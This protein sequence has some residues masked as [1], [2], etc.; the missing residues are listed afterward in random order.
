MAKFV[1]WYYVSSTGW[2]VSWYISYRWSELIYAA[3]QPDG[4]FVKYTCNLLVIHKLE[5]DTVAHS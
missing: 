2:S 3:L 5:D 4:L 1:S